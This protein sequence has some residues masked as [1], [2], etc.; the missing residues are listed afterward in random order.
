MAASTICHIL[1]QCRAKIAAGALDRPFGDRVNGDEVV[2]VDTQRRDAEAVS[3]RRQRAGAAACYSLKGRDRPLVVDHVEDHRRVVNAGE[4][5]GGVEIA[6]RRAPLAHPGRSD[7]GVVLDRARHRPTHRLRGLCGEVAR[8]A[9]EAV[10]AARIHDRELAALQLVAA[11]R[12]DLVD[13][14]DHRVAALDQDALLAIAREDH[15]VRSQGHAGRDARRLF[16]RALH[17]EAGFALP[18]TSKHALVKSARHCH[19]T[20]HFAQR[21]RIEFG[22]PR[23]MRLI[24]FAEHAHQ[25]KSHIA[26]FARVAGLVGTCHAPRIGYIYMREVDRITRP[27][28]RFGNMQRKFR[29]IIPLRCTTLGPFGHRIV[30]QTQSYA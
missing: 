5:A 12:I 21:I 10:F 16:A 17:V 28:F 7:A 6:F 14:L 13:H 24:V 8:D 20:E 9:E 11:V 15:I 23:P 25:A 30:S 22:V 27:E 18:L 3:A 29:A 26:H 1:Y 2:A 4:C 19:V